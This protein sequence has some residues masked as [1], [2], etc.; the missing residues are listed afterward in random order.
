MSPEAT[1]K[2]LMSFVSC[3]REAGLKYS[4]TEGAAV[5]AWDNIFQLQSFQKHLINALV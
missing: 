2:M 3:F 5:E 1:S 4:V